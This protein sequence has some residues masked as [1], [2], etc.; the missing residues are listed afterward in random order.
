MK[1]TCWPRFVM[2]SATRWPRDYADTPENGPGLALARTWKTLTTDWSPSNPCSIVFLTGAPTC[3][4][5][6]RTTGPSQS[7]G[8]IEPGAR[9]AV[10][11]S[12]RPSSNKPAKAWHPNAPVPNHT[13]PV[14]YTVPGIHRAEEPALELAKLILEGRL[15]EQRAAGSK[16]VEPDGPTLAESEEKPVIFE[17]T[18]PENFED[19]DPE[20]IGQVARQIIGT[21]DSRSVRLNNTSFPWRTF[22]HSDAGCSGTLISPTTIVT[23]AHCVYNT[24]NNTWIKAGSNWPKYGRGADAG[25]GTIY[26]Y[27]RFTCYTVTVPGGWVDKNDVKYDY[28]VLKLNCSQSSSNWLGS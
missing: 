24:V 27:G 23:A 18:D 3:L 16:N 6:A 4:A 8:I 17:D 5:T 25:D 11:N 2:S 21:T 28:A 7:I 19:T 10:P 22:V 9:S 12:S 26:P 1:T 13:Q 14:R 20:S 15:P